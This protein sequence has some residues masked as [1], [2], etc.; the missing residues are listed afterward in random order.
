MSDPAKPVFIS[1]AREDTEAVRQIAEALR[2]C[3]IEAWFD[4]DELRGGDSWDRKIRGQIRTCGLFV[5]IISHRTEARTEGYFRREWKMAAERTHDMAAGVP[6]LMPVAIDPVAEGEA[7]VPEEFLRVQWTRL[8]GGVPTPGFVVQVRRL[9]ESPR[10]TAAP[11][12]P[13]AEIGRAH[14]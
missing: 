3:G 10:R 11:M 7:A 13:E 14:V 12:R 1:Y 6:F 9:L 4:Q 8:P 2:A 5:P